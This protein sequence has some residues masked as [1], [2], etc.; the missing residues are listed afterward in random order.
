MEAELRSLRADLDVERLARHRLERRL[1]DLLERFE[2]LARQHD[3]Q[4][5]LSAMRIGSAEAPSSSALA[6]TNGRDALA[7]LAAAQAQYLREEAPLTDA[8]EPQVGTVN[9]GDE[10]Y[11]A[12]HRQGSWQGEVRDDGGSLERDESVRPRKVTAATEEE[13]WSQHF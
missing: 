8:N 5:S 4:S 12:A 13:Y 11:W 7:A 1:D 2:H 9:A 6:D 10:T 3:A